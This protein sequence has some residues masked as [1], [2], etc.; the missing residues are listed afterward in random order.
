MS[1]RM[2]YLALAASVLGLLL[3]TFI[4]PS[5]KPPLSSLSDVSASSLEKTVRLEGT[6]SRAHAFE[7]GS[8]I[9]TLSDSESDVDVY[10]PY[11]VAA[12]LKDILSEGSVV[13][14]TGTVQMYK[15]RLEV[16]V[17][18]PGNVVLK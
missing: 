15:G 5:V 7:G 18:R 11:D 10:L 9:L 2:L 1:D 14:L 3:I 4:A 6:V 16:V 8:M 12:E 13:E 17:E